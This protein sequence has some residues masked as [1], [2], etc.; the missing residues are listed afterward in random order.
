[1]HLTSFRPLRSP[2]SPARRQPAASLRSDVPDERLACG[3]IAPLLITA[4]TRREVKALARR[5]HLAS[6]SVMPFVEVP[7]RG[8][9]ADPS[10]LTALWL[11]LLD[12]SRGGSLL[13]TDVEEMP[14]D[15]QH[16]VMGV[17]DEIQVARP[18]SAAVRLMSGTTTSLLGL[19][20]GGTFSERLFY[21]LNVLHLKVTDSR[22]DVVP[23]VG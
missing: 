22:R 3:S 5:I 18:A 9:P 1:M 7:V 2:L 12:R 11:A 23:T 17:I 13:M 20:A 4:P 19:V 21:Q 15:V 10:A 16:R 8:L 6:R 14:A